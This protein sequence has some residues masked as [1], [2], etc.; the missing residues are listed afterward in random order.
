MSE[1]TPTPPASRLWIGLPAVMVL[2]TCVASQAAEPSGA[3]DEARVIPD[4]RWVVRG[5]AAH[6]AS[7]ARKALAKQA[8]LVIQALDRITCAKS[9]FV[10]PEVREEPAVPLQPAAL[11][12]APA[13]DPVRSNHQ[14]SAP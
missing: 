5:G 4:L 7:E 14:T 6:S 11:R 9:S 2:A 3:A 8:A 13:L 12:L 10:Q 1:R